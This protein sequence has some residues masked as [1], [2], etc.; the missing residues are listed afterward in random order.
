MPY[1]SHASELLKVVDVQTHACAKIFQI[2]R[3]MCTFECKIRKTGLKKNV[4]KN[5][6]K[7]GARRATFVPP[8]SAMTWGQPK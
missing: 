2:L 4:W 6:W 1:I 7:M 8:C 3:K 5:S